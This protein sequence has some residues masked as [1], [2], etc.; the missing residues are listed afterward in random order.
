MQ[1]SRQVGAQPIKMTEM[2]RAQTTAWTK[3]CLSKFSPVRSLLFF[4][5][6]GQYLLNMIE[7]ISSLN[8]AEFVNIDMFLQARPCVRPGSCARGGVT[9]HHS[10][11]PTHPHSHRP[12]PG[13]EYGPLSGLR[14]SQPNHS[15]LKLINVVNTR[16]QEEEEEDH[17]RRHEKTLLLA[18]GRPRRRRRQKR[19]KASPKLA[20]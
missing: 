14:P 19:G 5:V 3:S 15:Q 20:H 17:T 13:D 6:P 2:F 18:N 11:K 8:S 10:Y 9:C 4:C 7:Y 16:N 1:S 12:Q